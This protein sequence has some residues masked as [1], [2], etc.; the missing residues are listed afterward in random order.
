MKKLITIILTVISLQAYAQGKF[1]INGTLPDESQ[2]GKTVYLS[3]DNTLIDSCI[4]AKNT[5]HFE[6][7]TSQSL[8]LASITLI[9]KKHPYRRGDFNGFILEAGEISISSTGKVG[10]TPHNEKFQALL[11]KQKAIQEQYRLTQTPQLR[12]EFITVTYN[13]LKENM[14]NGIGE[15]LLGNAIQLFEAKQ[16][17]ELI[18]SARPSFQQKPEIQA[19]LQELSTFQ[20]SIGDKFVDMKLKNLEG[21]DVSISDYI[22]KNKYILI[23]FWASWCGPCIRENP[24]LVEAYKKYKSKGFEIVGISLD[25]SQPKWQQAVKNLDIAWPQ[26]SDL[27]GWNSVAARTYKVNSI[28]MSF[29][30]N[31]EGVVVG[32]NLRGE[33]LLTKL[34]ELLK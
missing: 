10:G 24:T 20:P 7:I 4:I 2:S 8:E 23:D 6:G 29:L 18:K 5:F 28:P 32:K 25:E 30:L 9:D 26:M 3:T 31:G 15:S 17:V 21:K 12:D 22:G 1:V 16:V 19:L 33:L 11:D 13:Y 27:G 34:D 14:S